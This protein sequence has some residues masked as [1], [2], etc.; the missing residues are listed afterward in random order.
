MHMVTG[1]STYQLQQENMHYNKANN[2]N[3][4]CYGMK[5]ILKLYNTICFQEACPCYT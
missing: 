1:W 3:A 4:I 2:I 5:N